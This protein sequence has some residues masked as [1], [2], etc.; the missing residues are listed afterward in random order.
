MSSGGIIVRIGDNQFHIDPGIGAVQRAGEFGANL[1]ENTAILL[2]HAHI[3]HA[4]DVNA[5]IDA[6]TYS[7]LDKKGVLIANQTALNGAEGYAPIIPD[8]YKN[9]LERFIAVNRNQRIG[10]NDVEIKTITARHND[11]NSLGFKFFTPEFTLTYT[12]DT[13]YSPDIVE[14]Y[15]KSNILIMNV[16]S[17]KKPSHNLCTKDAIKII[18]KVNPRLAI[19]T[20][21]GYEMIKEDPLYEVREIQKQTGVQ[22]IAA[23]DGMIINPISYSASEGQKTLQKFKEGSEAGEQEEARQEE[24]EEPKAEEQEESE[25]PKEENQQ[26]LGN[27]EQ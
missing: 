14:S 24:Q 3:N 27:F 8:Y 18:Q 26:H 21:F 4:N 13:V 17:I 1:R 9:L 16:P 15:M 6:M 23:K 22:T 7:G 10:I 5:V 12:G 25:E 19:I 11:P 20:H 2:S